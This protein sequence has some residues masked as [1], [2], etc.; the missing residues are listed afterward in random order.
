MIPRKIHRMSNFYEILGVNN[1]ANEAEIKKAYRQL[2][3]KYHPDRNSSEEA[4]SKIQKINEAYE[5]LSDEQRRQQYDHELKHGGGGGMPPMGEEFHD[6]NHIFNMM[7][8]GG[9]IPGMH[10]INIQSGGPGIRIFHGGMPGMHAM[11][12]HHVHQEAEPIQTVIKIT[13]EQSFHGCVFPLEIE[14]FNIEN[15]ARTTEK[16][17]LYI[18][19]PQ[20]IDDNE[21]IVIQGKG[22]RIH[23][24]SSDVRIIIQLENTT[25]FKRSG[26]DLIYNKKTTLKEALCGFT[27]E[28]VHLNGKHLS[29]NNKNNHSV[30]KPNFTKVVPQLGMVRDNNYGNLLIV[31]DVE[32]PDSLTVEQITA[33]EGIL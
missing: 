19:I 9:G 24:H 3:L 26:M 16:E 13:L 7:F 33:L 32:F 30:I 14:R 28:I 11:F 4:V 21:Q 23:D 27:F 29:I 31:F 5:T 2:S 15:N 6:I 22:N 17:T 1:E 12:H 25:T 18:T 10:G 20:G 8:G